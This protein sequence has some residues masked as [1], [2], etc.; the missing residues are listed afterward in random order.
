VPAAAEEGA[1]RSSRAGLVIAKPHRKRHST[2][3][4]FDHP[5]QNPQT[6]AQ[7]V[8][9]EGKADRQKEIEP[10][11]FV[12]PPAATVQT[13]GLRRRKRRLTTTT[14]PIDKLQTHDRGIALALIDDGLK[15]DLV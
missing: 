5:I 6:T 12:P 1:G 13:I 11:H 9:D 3:S 10:P 7:P 8:A 4:R 14:V 2:R 15:F